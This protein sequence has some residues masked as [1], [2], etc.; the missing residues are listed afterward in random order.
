MA[1]EGCGDN[2]CKV[3]RPSVGTNGG[4]R[5]HKQGERTAARAIQTLNN[6]RHALREEI[7]NLIKANVNC[8][9]IYTPS[10]NADSCELH[11]I[12]IPKLHKLYLEN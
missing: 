10:K 2:S 4:C 8:T 6:Q 1:Y 5:C 3:K 12:Y 11:D 7:L 9:C